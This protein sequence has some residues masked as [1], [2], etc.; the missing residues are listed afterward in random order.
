[1][2]DDKT[3]QGGD[4]DLPEADPVADD[5]VISDLEEQFD[6]E[7]EDGDEK[8]EDKPRAVTRRT[9]KAPVKKNV[10]TKKRSESTH[11]EHDPYQA[12]N[13]AQFVRQSAGELKKVVWPT[14][15]ELTTLFAVVLVFVL[16][17][18]LYVGVLDAAFGWTLL[19]LFGGTA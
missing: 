10:P 12:R 1:M 17:M 18:V 13:P 19:K 5:E 9:S 2:S 6:E 11:E 15:N 8:A 14:W 4:E 16:F 7:T 3:Q